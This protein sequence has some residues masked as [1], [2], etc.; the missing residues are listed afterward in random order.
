MRRGN[1]HLFNDMSQSSEFK[2]QQ[3]NGNWIDILSTSLAYSIL[4]ETVVECRLELSITAIQYQDI[5]QEQ[6][7]NLIPEIKGPHAGENFKTDCPILLN[8]LLKPD[9]LSTLIE[10]AGTAEE[11]ATYL[12]ELSQQQMAIEIAESIDLLLQTENWFCLS[13][14]Q[15]QGEE[16][17]G[18]TT[19][20]NYVNPALLNVPETT[21]D[22]L[23]EGITNFVR[24]WTEANLAE[25]TQ[26]ATIQFLKGIS[27]TFGKLLDGALEGLEDDDE[28]N[29]PLFNAVK[30]FFE[31]E[32]WPFAEITKVT[33][34]R[35][36]FRGNNGQWSCYAKVNEAE[37]TF[38]FYSICPVPSLETR[39]GAVSEFITRAN[40]GMVL[41]NFELDY[42]D[43]EI[44][45]KT[46]IDVEGSTLDSALIKQLVYT[47]VLTMDQY[48]P[49]IIAVLEQGMEPEV[50]IA[51][52]ESP[53]SP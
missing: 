35:L 32:N 18:F 7:F 9:L 39:L 17:A 16:E 49:G 40:Y 8:L 6:S 33:A 27:D 24:D 22:Q 45:Y 10:H 19:F 47:N 1:R 52:V 20:W 28:S 25:A 43:G 50:A 34:L 23:A 42:S 38:L 41:G 14:K 26:T 4:A 51:I 5:E 29:G 37:Q 21:S 13:V 2:V 12:S 44:R 30:D 53:T 15:K 48:L 36:S 3:S 31:E 46:S 11:A